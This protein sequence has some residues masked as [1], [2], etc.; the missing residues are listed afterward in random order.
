MDISRQNGLLDLGQL[1]KHIQNTLT[2]NI[3]G[4]MVPSKSF[5]IA[6]TD[7]QNSY[8]QLRDKC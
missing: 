6:L 7:R 1:N 5:S 3:Q 2:S 4:P 8:V